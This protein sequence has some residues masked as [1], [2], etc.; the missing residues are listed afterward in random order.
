MPALGTEKQQRAFA[1]GRFHLEL[2]GVNVGMLQSVDGGHFKSEAIGQQVGGE[3][4]VT[5]YPGRQKFE[6]ITVTAGTSMAPAFWKW[7]KA[8]IDNN[9]TRR[10][11]AIVACDFDGCERARRTFSEALISEIQFPQLDAKSKNPAYISVKIA[12]EYLEYQRKDGSRVQPPSATKQKRFIPA[13]YRIN[14][15]RGDLKTMHVVKVDA[16]TIKQNIIQNPVGNEKWA[17]I[18]PGRVEHPTISMYVPETYAG[19]WFTWWKKFVGEIQHESGNET[20]GSIE[21]LDSDCNDT[22]MTLSFKGIGITGI[23]YDK[24]DA[25]SDAIRTVK[26]DLYCETMDFSG[27]AGTEG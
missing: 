16:I 15:E 18:E 22:L 19:P 13:N 26:V 10:T 11:G 2:D 7:I 20:T 23:T 14:L 8:S 5:K 12:P 1:N 24:L 27:G 3:G 17:R 9:Y 25:G 6:E 4:L 21:Y